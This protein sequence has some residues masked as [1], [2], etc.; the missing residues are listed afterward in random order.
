M[1]IKRDALTVEISLDGDQWCALV[2][3]NLME[4]VAGFGNTPLEALKALCDEFA[5]TPHNLHTYILG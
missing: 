5:E 1:T 4:G 2:G 3:A